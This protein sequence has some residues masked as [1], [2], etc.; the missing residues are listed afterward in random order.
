[1]SNSDRLSSPSEVVSGE[2]AS[3]ITLFTISDTLGDS[4]D[5]EEESSEES[6]K[7]QKQ[8][9]EEPR[10]PRKEGS[11]RP[12]GGRGRPPK[13]AETRSPIIK[14]MSLSPASWLEHH[15]KMIISRNI[16]KDPSCLVADDVSASSPPDALVLFAGIDGSPPS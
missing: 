8:T 1:M 16:E 12:L 7:D 14:S 9:R 13:R 11:P 2:T 15:Y 3:A 4:S 10:F 5:S 6:S